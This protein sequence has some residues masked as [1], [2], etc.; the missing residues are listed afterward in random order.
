MSNRVENSSSQSQ[1]P[2]GQTGADLLHIPALNKGTAF[3]KEERE[4]LG[5]RG[6]L[7]PHIHSQEEQVLRVMENFH[8]KPNNLEKYIHMMALQGRNETLFYR[9]VLDHI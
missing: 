2:E 3:T 4:A 9:V 8:R 6:L 7:P 5:L 1:V